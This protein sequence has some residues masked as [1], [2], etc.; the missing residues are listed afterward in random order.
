MS[1]R[2]DGQKLKWK[3]S[4]DQVGRRLIRCGVSKGMFGGRHGRGI[5][6]VCRRQVE[7]WRRRRVGMGGRI[8]RRILGHMGCLGQRHWGRLFP[9]DDLWGGKEE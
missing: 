4:W 6:F 9:K 5:M 1:F 7:V 8:L 3:T 2:G